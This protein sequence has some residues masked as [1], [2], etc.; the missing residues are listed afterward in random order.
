MRGD[1]KTIVPALAKLVKDEDK[2]VRL[3]VVQVFWQYGAQAV[4]HL[5]ERRLQ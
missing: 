2:Q 4:P 5:I 1:P 3:A